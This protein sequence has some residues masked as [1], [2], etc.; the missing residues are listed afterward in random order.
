MQHLVLTILLGQ[1]ATTPVIQS[2]AELMEAPPGQRA[3]LFA[4]LTPERRATIMKQRM[5]AW[6][7]VHLPDLSARQVATV[8]EAIAPVTPELYATPPSRE[9]NQRYSDLTRRL[10]CALSDDL[11]STLTDFSR[12]PQRSHRT[13]RQAADDWI[14]WTVNCVFSK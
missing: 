4:S 14:D 2:Y 11:A 12:P 8:R 3:T 6:L 7:T 5:E 1:L 9:L 13:W 10:A